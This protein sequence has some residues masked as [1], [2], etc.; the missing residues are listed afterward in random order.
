MNLRTRISD[1]LGSK[2]TRSLSLV[3]VAA[4]SWVSGSGLPEAVMTDGQGV[5]VESVAAADTAAP[6]KEKTNAESTAAAFNGV[7]QLVNM[8]FLPAT[9]LAGWLLSPDW[10]LGEIFGLRPIIH[11]FWVLVSNIVYVI[12]AF[13]LIAMAFMNI[14]GIGQDHYAMKK[15]LPRFVTGI[16]M[17]PFTWFAVSA[18]LSVSNLLTASVLRLPADM[19]EQTTAPGGAAG[20]TQREVKFN[21]PKNCTLNFNK[22]AGSGSTSGT[23][24]TP[25]GKFFDCPLGKGEVNEVKAK[26]FLSS[27][28]GP[29]G[30]LMV[31]AYDIFRVQEF[32]AIT[33][34]NLKSVSGIVDMLIMLGLWGI[35]FI[36]YALILLALVFALFTRAFYLWVMAIFSPL[37]GLFYYLEGKGKLAESMKSLSFSSFLSLAL[38]PVYVSAALSFGLIF[39]KLAAD[40]T[41]TPENSTFFS[42]VKPGKEK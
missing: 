32:Q 25:V 14:F 4:L 35:F 36:V 16:L 12:F 3:A 39:V 29:Y 24:S 38:V 28:K 5:F 31:Y 17:V 40:T 13:L 20:Q 34:D 10:T 15:A 19:I 21:M 9:M 7:I 41:L 33:K 30:I 6:A 26:D 37:F 8:L 1:L 18:T 27:D 23:N 22:L 11:K 42:D 2:K